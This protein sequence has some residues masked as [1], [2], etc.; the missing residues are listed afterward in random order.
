MSRK[1]HAEHPDETILRLRLAG[2][3]GG[4]T[5][6]AQSGGKAMGAVLSAGLNS[7][8]REK[9]IELGAVSEAEI[10]ERISVLRRLQSAKALQAR[11]GKPKAG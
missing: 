4:L 10:A 9:A 11:W 3:V 7:K 6:V 1:Q 5:R 2:R 8:L